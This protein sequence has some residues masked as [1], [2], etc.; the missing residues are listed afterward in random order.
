MIQS[1][2]FSHSGKDEYK[3][4]SQIKIKHQDNR[5]DTNIQK[6]TVNV[7]EINFPMKKQRSSDLIKREV[8]T[9]CLKL[10]VEIK[11]MEKKV[12]QRQ[13]TYINISK[14]SFLIWIRRI[15]DST[16]GLLLG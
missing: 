16:H 1:I 4:K 12:W 13:A 9:C 8:S 11:R 5:F 14:P 7:D 3:K 10:H 15:S 6:F 2:W